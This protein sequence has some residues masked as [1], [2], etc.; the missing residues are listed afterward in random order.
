MSR[1]SWVKSQA[2]CLDFEV[3]L[4]CCCHRSLLPS[5]VTVNQPPLHILVRATLVSL[6]VFQLLLTMGSQRYSFLPLQFFVV[7]NSL[8]FLGSYLQSSNFISFSYLIRALSFFKKTYF[9]IKVQL[10]Y[11]VVLISPILQGVA[12]THTHPFFFFRVTPAARGR[13]QARG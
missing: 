5:K 3:L 7:F 1:F 11:S 12:V 8:G 6:Q 13:S 9:L 2:L 10:I 4:L